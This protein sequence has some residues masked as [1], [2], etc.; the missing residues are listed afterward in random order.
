MVDYSK[1]DN[2]SFSSDEEEEASI[3]QKKPNEQLS[4]NSII[5]S[6]SPSPH[7][8]S[9]STPSPSSPFDLGP[10]HFGM[11]PLTG[12]SRLLLALLREKERGREGLK[13]AIEENQRLKELLETLP[14][15]RR[16]DVMVPLGQGEKK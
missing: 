13:R 3:P 7:S 16:H 1:W 12:T 6:P 15:K 14:L 8:P 11:N 4:S 2:M 9:S 10:S 5:P